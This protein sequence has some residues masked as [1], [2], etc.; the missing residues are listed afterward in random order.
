MENQIFYD[1]SEKEIYVIEDFYESL[2]GHRSNILSQ[3]HY[4]NDELE[5]LKTENRNKFNKIKLLLY[6]K[7]LNIMF[8]ILS[9]NVKNSFRIFFEKVKFTKINSMGFKIDAEKKVRLLN[10]FLF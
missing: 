2:T 3:L 5:E 9:I 8:S 7:F 4:P 1:D 6:Q 10:K